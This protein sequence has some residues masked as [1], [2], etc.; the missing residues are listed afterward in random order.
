MAGTDEQLLHEIQQRKQSE[1][2]LAERIRI[3]C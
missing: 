1:K 2:K 3:A